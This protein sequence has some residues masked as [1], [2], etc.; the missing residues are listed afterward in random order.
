MFFFFIKGIKRKEKLVHLG[1]KPT[2]G[3]WYPTCPNTPTIGS[4]YVSHFIADGW[5][6]QQ[7]GKQ[8]EQGDRPQENIRFV[9]M[10]IDRATV[11]SER[12]GVR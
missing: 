3:H 12:Y 7:A 2:I 4:W 8:D 5:A 6:R 1:T 9:G 11:G 10:W